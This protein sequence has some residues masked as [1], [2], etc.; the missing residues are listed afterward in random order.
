MQQARRLGTTTRPEEC[1]R[2]QTLELGTI[3]RRTE[4]EIRVLGQNSHI[5]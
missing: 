3:G 1:D 5:T 2:L 4:C